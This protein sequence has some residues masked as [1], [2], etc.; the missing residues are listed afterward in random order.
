MEQYNLRDFQLRLLEILKQIDTVCRNHQLTYYI[1][2]GTLLGAVRHKG[3]IPW[4][5]DIDIIMPRPDYDQL[6][7]HA[8]DWLPNPLYMMTGKNSQNYHHAFAKVVDGNTHLVERGVPMGLYV[9]IFPIDGMTRCRLAQQIHVL[10]Y[11]YITKKMLYFCCR[12]PYK[13][14]HGL[15]CWWTLF[16][17]KF[18]GYSHA[19]NAINRMQRRYDYSSHEMTID[20]DFNLAGI[21][22]KS[23]LGTPTEINFE[24]CLFFGPE[25]PAD[26]LSRVYGANYMTPPP[27][28]QRRIHYFSEV[29][30]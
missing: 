8:Q 15:S 26:Y 22:P 13:H 7:A 9:D 20:H 14:G 4:D 27:P 17:R 30:F 5:D 25:H 28:E 10:W 6:I 21:M 23:V 19:H 3:F 12:D 16:C 2:A 11:R 1:E 29:K 18:Y 24:G